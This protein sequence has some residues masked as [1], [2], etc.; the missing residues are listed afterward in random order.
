MERIH[1]ERFFFLNER[2]N[3]GNVSQ[4]LTSSQAFKRNVQAAAVDDPFALTQ[5][6]IQ[7][8]LSAGASPGHL[9]SSFG[10]EIMTSNS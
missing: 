7:T 5:D 10:G 6:L 4:T 2:S 1:R 8:Q 9:T 3:S